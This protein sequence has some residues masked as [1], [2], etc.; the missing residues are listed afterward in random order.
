MDQKPRCSKRYSML[1]TEAVSACTLLNSTS[2]DPV[3]HH[4]PHAAVSPTAAAYRVY[5]LPLRLL[6]WPL[7][8]GALQA[9]C[10]RGVRASISNAMT[11]RVAQALSDKIPTRWHQNCLY[12]SPRAPTSGPMP[13]PPS[14]PLRLAVPRF[15]S[16]AVPWETG[17][18][19]ADKARE[20]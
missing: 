16:L 8:L 7:S 9:S 5:E 13:S 4:R 15:L 3:T 10:R 2:Q 1:P 14:T 6:R 11:Q 17:V 18:P 19:C 12:S 20:C